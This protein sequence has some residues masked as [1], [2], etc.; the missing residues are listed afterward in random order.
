MKITINNKEIELKVGMRA[1]MLF[2]Q[3]AEK[4]YA[5]E[6]LTDMLMFYYAV[7]YSSDKSKSITWDMFI[8]WIDENN[9]SINEFNEFINQYNERNNKVEKDET[10]SDEQIEEVKKN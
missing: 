4:T 5:P 2:E 6:T 10:I 3:M 8:D 1:F 9:D 7:V